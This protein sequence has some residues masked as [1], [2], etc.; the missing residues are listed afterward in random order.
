MGA[1][2]LG[3][4]R[5]YRP[6]EGWLVFGLAYAAAMCLPAAALDAGWLPGMDPAFWLATLALLST[7]LFH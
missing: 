2:L 5:R 7:F 1:L 3:L 4:L 6:R